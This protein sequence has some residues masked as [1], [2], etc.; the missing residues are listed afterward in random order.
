[1]AGGRFCG[2]MKKI[3]KGK[4]EQL[5]RA[6]PQGR[7]QLSTRR[8]AT[9]PYDLRL[10]STSRDR[11]QYA[12]FPRIQEAVAN[13]PYYLRSDQSFHL[14]FVA[15]LANKLS[16]R[17]LLLAGRLFSANLPIA[18]GQSKNFGR[19]IFKCVRAAASPSLSYSVSN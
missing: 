2:R 1:M 19:K 15:A 7:L 16:L 4:L 9:G 17:R 5:F 6:P 3:R 18:K 12:L 11:V 8:P 10:Y 13:F 14:R